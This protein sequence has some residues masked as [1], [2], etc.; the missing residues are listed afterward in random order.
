[1]DTDEDYN[2]ESDY[3][4]ENEEVPKE[5]S[6]KSKNLTIG[7]DVDIDDDVDNEDE[8]DDLQE[9]ENDELDD[10][11]DSIGNLSDEENEN[12]IKPLSPK[13]DVIK[14]FEL[15]DDDDDDSE[16]ENYLQKFDDSVE[17]SIKD[18]YYPELIFHNNDEV[19]TLSKVTKNSNG[20]IVDPLHK[21]L[22][23]ITKYEKAR[24]IGERAR[25]INAG[26]NPLINVDPSVIDGYLIALQ[27]FNEKKTPFIIKRPLPNGACEY[28]KLQDLEILV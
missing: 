12:V 20:E 16:D 15:S 14:Q 11:I 9:P 5:N 2:E 26:A 10:E 18:N 24:I 1:M 22:P 23:F 3:E 25:Q 4:S 6:I 27:E 28:W 7:D 19:E 13:D 21:T 8:L 17:K